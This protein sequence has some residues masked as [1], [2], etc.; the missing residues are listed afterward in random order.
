MSGITLPANSYCK[1]YDYRVGFDLKRGKLTFDISP[2]VFQDPAGFIGASLILTS[3]S[4]IAAPEG[5]VIIQ[6]DMAK[7]YEINLPKVNGC[8]SL[9][10]LYDIVTDHTSGKH[11]QSAISKARIFITS[12]LQGR[13]QLYNS[14]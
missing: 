10:S 2:T 12:G 5:F 7:V 3:P 13:Y 9:G 6:G 11:R 8:L 1:V 14:V 4:G